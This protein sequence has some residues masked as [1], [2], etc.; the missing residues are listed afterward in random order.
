MKVNKLQKDKNKMQQTIEQKKLHLETKNGNPK[1]TF[2]KGIRFNLRQR[3]N[4][5]KPT[6]I[7]CVI[8]NNGKKYV[9]NS[10]VKVIPAQWSKKRQQAIVSNEFCALDN[11]NNKIANDRLQSIRQHYSDTITEIKDNPDNISNLISIFA[12]HLNIRRMVK[13]K[14]T[15]Q[16]FTS[17]LYSI[18]D[19]DIVT[20]N[21]K[22]NRGTAILQWERFIKQQGITDTPDNFNYNNWECF[23]HWLL[24]QRTKDG[25]KF[26][27]GT[28]N[29]YQSNIKA[30]INRWNKAHP[31]TPINTKLL[32]NTKPHK[33]PTDTQKQSKYII[34]SNEE[35]EKIY[36]TPII[37]GEKKM[38]NWENAKNLFVFQCLIGCRT[39]DLHR[40]FEGNYKTKESKGLTY[41]NY[42][43][44]KTNEQAFTPIES[45]TAKE[46]FEWVKSLSEFPFK[47]DATYNQSL[48]R[49]FEVLGYTQETEYTEQRGME[50][51]TGHAPTYKIIHPHTGRHIF[52]TIMYYR[53]VPLEQVKIMTGHTDTAILEAVYRKLDSEKELDKLTDTL[54]ATQ[55]AKQPK[56][57]EN[58]PFKTLSET[59]GATGHNSQIEAIREQIK[60][61]QMGFYSSV[62]K[63]VIG[64]IIDT[65]QHAN[66][67][68]E[69]AC[70]I[71]LESL[72]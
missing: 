58:K 24:N 71:L 6:I 42:H 63:S 16:S 41:I 21:T 33:R 59:I 62:D 2:L 18:N 27:T 46:L 1:Q 11:M 48:K 57:A 25:K 72:S 55:Q 3:H 61:Y 51:V 12:E 35:L 29:A 39:S 19:N 17:E 22:I 26:T 23:C 15:E 50:I 45:Q 14:N 53:G 67:S 52:A 9:F 30:M 4:T 54:T 44:E 69:K 56:Q 65:A 70:E 31:N 60:F 20:S 28:I 36:M 38:T 49:A 64:K 13:K 8:R 5:D 68:P 47:Y 32:E 10:S 66:C 34:L 43:S 37:K 40:I 7:Y